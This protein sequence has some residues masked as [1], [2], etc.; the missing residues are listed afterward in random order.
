MGTSLNVYPVAGLVKQVKP[1]VPRLLINRE[2]VGHWRDSGT[3]G[4]NYRDV[5]WEGDCDEG[6]EELRK[7]LGWS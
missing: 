5:C 4:E 3:P 6:A 1:L 7:L 2:R